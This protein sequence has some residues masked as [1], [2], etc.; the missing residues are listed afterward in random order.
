MGVLVIGSLVGEE[1]WWNLLCCFLEG[2]EDN[3]D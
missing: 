3:R 2:F 1:L